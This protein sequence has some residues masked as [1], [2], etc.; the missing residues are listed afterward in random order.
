[1]RLALWALALAI[2]FG[3]ASAVAAAESCAPNKV[4][5][6][7]LR[8]KNPSDIH[9]NWAPPNQVGMAWSLIHVRHEDRFLGGQL[10]TPRGGALAGRVFVLASEWD[11]EE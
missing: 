11:C 5:P 7:I 6:K 1:M 2:L 8:S 9:P 10:V 3:S 4:G